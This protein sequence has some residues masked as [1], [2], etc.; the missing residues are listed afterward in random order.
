MHIVRKRLWQSA[1]QNIIK[2]KHYSISGMGQIFHSLFYILFAFDIVPLPFH[3]RNT[4]DV[5]EDNFLTESKVTLTDKLL[6]SQGIDS[7]ES[8]PPA[9]SLSARRCLAM[10]MLIMY[11]F[12]DIIIWLCACVS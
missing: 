2:T 12:P 9:A 6:R 11:I 1:S 7:K 4:L 3:K 5:D 8:I 10:E